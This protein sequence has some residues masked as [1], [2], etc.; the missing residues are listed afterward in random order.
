M[1]PHVN[2]D[3][4][5]KNKGLPIAEDLMDQRVLST[6]EGHAALSGSERTSILVQ[7]YKPGGLH[8]PHEHEDKEQA[9]LVLSGKG[10]MHIGDDV[11]PIEKGTIVYAPPKVRHSTENTGDEDLVMML[12]DVKL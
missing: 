12:I 1:S 11:F 2:I 5:E 6:E 8:K 7:T 10:Q 9:F 3:D 4:V